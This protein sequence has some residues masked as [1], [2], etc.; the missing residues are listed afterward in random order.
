MYT[1]FRRFGG[2]AHRDTAQILLDANISIGGKSMTE[3]IADRTFLSREIVHANPHALHPEFF[4]DFTVSAK[5][6]AAK[7]I[8]ARGGRQTGCSEVIAH[9]RGAAATCMH[10]ALADAGIDPM[11][12]TNA[13][14]RIMSLHLE[15]ESDRAL[16]LIML[17][18]VTGCL[19]NPRCAVEMIDRFAA[20]ELNASLDTLVAPDNAHNLREADPAESRLGLVR[21]VGGAFR[22]PIHELS[23][24]P[25]GTVIGCLPDSDASIADV[26]V[27]VSRQHARIWRE[28]GRWFV[29]DLGSTNGTRVISGADKS[30]NIISAGDGTEASQPFELRNSDILCLGATTRFLVMK[31]SV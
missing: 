17:F 21:L 3:R 25:E 4:A 10:D 5:Q 31:L 7:L 8:A 13:V 12:Y 19:A 26:D 11:P 18:I 22:L 23:V 1:D 20:T 14:R 2:M 24:A 27:D 6:I 16:L 29:A 28:H 9:Y 15:L 30:V